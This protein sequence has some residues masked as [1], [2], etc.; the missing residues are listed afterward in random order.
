MASRCQWQS[1]ARAILLKRPG[2][3]GGILSRQPDCLLQAGPTEAELASDS[4]PESEPTQPSCA[5]QVVLGPAAA[6][7]NC[8]TGPGQWQAEGGPGGPGALSVGRTAKAH[9]ASRAPAGGPGGPL[10][11]KLPYLRP[12]TK[13][14]QAF[15]FN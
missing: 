10:T 6:A 13:V 4:D 9:R 2:P 15:G 12:A 5:R 7:R 11:E 3:A 1:R 14:P 8:G